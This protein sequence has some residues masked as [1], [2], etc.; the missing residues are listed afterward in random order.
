[1]QDF[2]EFKDSFWGENGFEELKKYMRLGNDFCKDLASILMERAEHE[3][4]YSKGLNRTSLR[5]QK[6][7][8]EFHGTLSDAWHQVAI[9]F[10][11]EAEMHK[12]LAS[13]LQ[14]EII[15]PLKILSDN[16]IKCRK[17]VELRVEKV[18][19]NFSDK[20][21]EDYKY[22]SRCFQL[23]KDIEKSMY[24]LDEAQKGIA[25]K[26]PNQKEIQKVQFFY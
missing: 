20:R 21:A 23:I 3:T 19:K 18:M 25:G 22:R 6:L 8:K 16:Q 5:L 26:P 7:S 13:T 24:N 15:K 9:Q 1:M 2:V 14:E 10:D 17:P 11:S 12:S 4:N